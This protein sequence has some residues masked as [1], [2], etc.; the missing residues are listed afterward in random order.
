M[1]VCWYCA[2]R[3][4]HRGLTGFPAVRHPECMGFQALCCNRESNRYKSLYCERENNLIMD[5]KA[6]STGKHGAEGLT[7][8]PAMSGL[9]SLILV[10]VMTGRCKES[11]ISVRGTLCPC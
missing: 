8:M 3:Q 11:L 5:F 9:A 4:S 7:P 6:C 10:Q 1:L 2:A